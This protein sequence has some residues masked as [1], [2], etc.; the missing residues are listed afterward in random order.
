MQDL[1]KL[2]KEIFVFAVGFVSFIMIFLAPELFPAAFG[3]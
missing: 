1:F 2:I 3:G